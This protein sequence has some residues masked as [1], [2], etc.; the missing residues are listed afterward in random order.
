MSSTFWK[1][2][3][4]QIV[5]PFA[6][7]LTSF[8]NLFVFFLKFDNKEFEVFHFKT[9]LFPSLFF[10]LP[11]NFLKRNLC[12]LNSFIKIYQLWQIVFSKMVVK[13]SSFAHVLLQ[14]G[15][16]SSHQELKSNSP[17]LESDFPPF[18]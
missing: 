14:C 16:T 15:I 1:L 18:I 17:P 9:N 5:C 13:K 3:L 10:L 2:S 7:H 6:G 12:T 8:V 4:H 11:P